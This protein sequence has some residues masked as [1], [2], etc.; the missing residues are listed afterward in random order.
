MSYKPSVS[1]RELIEAGVHYGHKTSRW[2]PR[3][4][5]YIFG[6]R[7]GVHIIDLQ[8]TLPLAYRAMQ[9]VFEV[10]RDNGRILMVGT[11][12]QVADE[13]AQTAQRC[14][15]YYVNHRWLGGMLTNWK[16][17]SR[18]IRKLKELN[19][20]LE[21]EEFE[22]YTKKEVLG[23]RRQQEKLN[24]SLGGITEMGGCPDLIFVIDS[25]RETLAM[26]E[27]RK[28]GIPIIAVLDSNS[29]PS[30]VDYPIPGNDDATR[31]IQ[32][33][34]RLIQEATLAGI[35]Q[36]L[37]ASGVDLGAA[38]DAPQFEAAFKEA[39]ASGDGEGEAEVKKAASK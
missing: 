27:A 29:D 15:Q 6:E 35:E 24:R 34:C 18:S 23:F 26:Q 21:K 38:Q 1:M 4:A 2:N 5:P 25:N 14:G 39:G 11:K 12:R 32:L 28:L 36:S 3:M 13:V 20:F 19:R 9:K 8:Q 7:N 37:R 17:V 22:G 16:T 10:V 30:D 33:Y 31:A